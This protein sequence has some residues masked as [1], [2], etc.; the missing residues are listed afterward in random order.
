[1]S[2]DNPG[3]AARPRVFF[4]VQ[5][6]LGIGHLL[7]AARVVKALS[8][9]GF[10]VMLALGGTPVAGLDVGT[11]AVL[12]LPPVKAG[13]AGFSALVHPDGRVFD[14]ADE[15]ARTRDLL[16]AFDRFAPDVLVLEA[17]PFGRRPMRFELRP[18]LERARTGQRSILVAASVRDILQRSRREDR[19]AETVALVQNAFDLVLVHGDPH[20]TKLEDT[21]PAA[22]TF[23]DKVIYTGIV[24]PER[25]VDAA[26][27]PTY[28]AIVSAGGGAV[29]GMLLE[30]ALRARPLTRIADRSWLVLAGPNLPPADFERLARGG[31][32]GI[33]FK[34]FVPDLASLMTRADVSVSQAGYNTVADILRARC[35]AVFVPFTQGGETEQTD[36]ADLLGRRGGYPAVAESDLTPERLAAAVNTA[37]DRPRPSLAFDLDGAEGTARILRQ[38]LAS[39]VAGRGQPASA[40]DPR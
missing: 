31:G 1:M 2:R 36:R 32:P 30:A 10:D 25:G 3:A 13:P 38:A 6:L 37:L 17:F 7:R 8:A 21:F 35:R 12:Q 33:E 9:D 5:H 19:I 20:L 22:A 39:G 40:T 16:V 4:Y 28:G 29:G 26:D 14:K 27:I 24:A 34:R 18:L 23:S 11:A 15:A